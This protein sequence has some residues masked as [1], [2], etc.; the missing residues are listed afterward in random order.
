M[1]GALNP[2]ITH[3]ILDAATA[4]AATG[5][6][7]VH[8]AGERLLRDRDLDLPRRDP[9]PWPAALPRDISGDEASID[10]ET[11]EIIA[12]RLPPRARQ[13][14]ADWARVHRVELRANWERAQRHEPIQPIAPLR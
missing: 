6:I 2:C 10:I 8:A 5:K 1:S 4:T 3:P 12:G 13:L 7:D 11:L 14:V 9:P